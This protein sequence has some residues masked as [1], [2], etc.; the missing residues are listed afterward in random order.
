MPYLLKRAQLGSVN[1]VKRITVTDT[2][3]NLQCLRSV[4]NLTKYK[5]V[6]VTIIKIQNIVYN[7]I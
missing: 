6:P 1:K 5:L 7:F 2:F 3:R 4:T